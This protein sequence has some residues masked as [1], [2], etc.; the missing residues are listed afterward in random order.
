L[1]ERLEITN[2]K[3]QGV[4]QIA[5]VIKSLKHNP[6]SRR[7]IVCAWI[8]K[9]VLSAS[10]PPCHCLFQFYV[11]NGELS[12]L[13]YQRSADL[14]C[15]V[16]FNVASYSI[17]TRMIAHVCDLRA[18]ELIH[19]MADAHVYLDHIE[20]LQEQIKRI[21]YPFPDLEINSEI[22]KLEDFT[23]KDLKV[24]NY[25]SHQKIKLNLSA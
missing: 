24:K 1:I 10:L 15:G 9:D 5:N 21:P 6:N 23:L 25:K 18:K 22:R 13:M 12:C 16:P 19:V 3:G 17:L 7:H 4:D 8:P 20:P 11:A 14:G 2:Y